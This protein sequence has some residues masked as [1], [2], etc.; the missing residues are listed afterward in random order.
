MA[1]VKLSHY[2]KKAP[3]SVS[4]VI[5][6]EAVVIQPLMGKVNVLN[7]MGAFIWNLADGSHSLE[8]IIGLIRVEYSVSQ[9][10]ATAD[11]LEFVQEMVDRNLLIIIEA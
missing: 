8:A 2:V 1:T 5:D 3:K 10:Q 7:E 11:A 9:E 6:N 4:N